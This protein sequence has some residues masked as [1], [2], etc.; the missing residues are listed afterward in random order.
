M[1]DL[2]TECHLCGK[3]LQTNSDDCIPV[4]DAPFHCVHVCYDCGE[5]HYDDV[6]VCRY[7]GERNLRYD[8]GCHNCE[9]AKT[10]NIR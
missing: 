5:D 7:C 8:D 6:P 1:S 10:R 3:T 4:Y 2:K 9:N